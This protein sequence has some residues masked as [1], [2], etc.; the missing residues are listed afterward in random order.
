MN[1]SI[2]EKTDIYQF[3]ESITSKKGSVT[4]PG[5]YMYEVLRDIVRAQ[6]SKIQKGITD[7]VPLHYVR[8]VQSNSFKQSHEEYLIYSLKHTVCYDMNVNKIINGFFQRHFLELI[9]QSKER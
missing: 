4:K 7:T 9:L 1:I 8:L 6:N 3:D 2:G 5:E